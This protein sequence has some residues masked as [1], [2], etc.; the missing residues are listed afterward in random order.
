MSLSLAA[1]V[2]KQIL[3]LTLAMLIMIV[4]RQVINLSPT[5]GFANSWSKHGF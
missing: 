2:T 1:I 5:N 4:N 3:P